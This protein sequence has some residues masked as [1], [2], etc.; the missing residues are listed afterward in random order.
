MRQMILTALLP[1]ALLACTERQTCESRAKSHM[2]DIDVQIRETRE[3]LARGY[4]YV[5]TQAVFTVGARVCSG[6]GGIVLCTRP[7]LPSHRRV[8]IDP[9]AEQAKLAALEKRK[10]AL[11][12]EFAHCAAAYPDG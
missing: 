6:Q 7:T 8:R 11:Q 1:I 12:G 4:A 9:D 5:E 10:I 2:Y 3:N